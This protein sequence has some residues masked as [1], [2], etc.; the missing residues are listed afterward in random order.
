MTT[1]QAIESPAASPTAKSAA[2][3]EM[4]TKDG[5]HPDYEA[6]DAWLMVG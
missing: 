4:R 2:F 3:N 1:K 6:L 5:L